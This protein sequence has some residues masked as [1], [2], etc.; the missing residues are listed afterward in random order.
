MDRDEQM[1]YD[2]GLLKDCL[3]TAQIERA[4]KRR[5]KSG[6]RFLFVVVF[7]FL[8]RPCLFPKMNWLDCVFGSSA[9]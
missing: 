6:L 3:Y 8:N 9:C 1:H 2:I 7:I 5:F 4:L